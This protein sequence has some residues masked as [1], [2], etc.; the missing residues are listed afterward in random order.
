M[1]YCYIIES[2]HMYYWRKKISLIS[3]L[4]N[5][6][7]PLLRE[8]SYCYHHNHQGQ[9]HRFLQESHWS[10]PLLHMG[11][12]ICSLFPDKTTWVLDLMLGFEVLT[13]ASMKMAVF[14]VVAPYSLVEVYQRFRGPC[15]LHHQGN[16][17]KLLPDYTPRRQPSWTHVILLLEFGLGFDHEEINKTHRDLNRSPQRKQETHNHMSHA[18]FLQ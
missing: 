4:Q 3:H 17:G 1:R 14:W 9:M 18:V 12:I 5:H 6:M 2:I 10:K 8:L 15:C 7:Y 16:V 11:S 13:A